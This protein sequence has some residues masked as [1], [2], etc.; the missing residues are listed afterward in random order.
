MHLIFF[1]MV[2]EFGLGYSH[3]FGYASC[4]YAGRMDISQR[5]FCY[6]TASNLE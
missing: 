3:G 1:R 6:F 5:G 2:D 4:I